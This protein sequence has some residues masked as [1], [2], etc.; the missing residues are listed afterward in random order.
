MPKSEREG[1]N[2]SVHEEY[3]GHGSYRRKEEPPGPGVLSL[4]RFK[5]FENGPQEDESR[6]PLGPM[7]PGIRR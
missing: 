4:C 3:R 1:P 5:L 2:G 6:E 7:D